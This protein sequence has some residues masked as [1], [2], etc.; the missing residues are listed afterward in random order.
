MLGSYADVSINGRD[1]FFLTLIGLIGILTLLLAV[2]AGLGVLNMV[3][4]HTR[5]RAHDLGI[6]KAIGM[7]PRQTIA[8][9]VCSVAGTGL[10]AGPPG[11]P[12]R[13]GGAPVRAASD[14]ARGGN[15]DSSQLPGCLPGMGTRCAGLGRSGHSRGR[16]D[17]AV[18]LGRPSQH[19]GC[20]AR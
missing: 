8:M 1:P 3:V 5:E 19:R 9:V 11:G 4:L 14:G 6:F 10:V 13:N 7:T 17:A 16:G 18:S 15:R 12:G 2:A 20:A